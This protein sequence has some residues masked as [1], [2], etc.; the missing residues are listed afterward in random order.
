MARLKLELPEFTL[1]LT[2]VEVR[3]TDLNYGNHLANQALL[4]LLHE[5]RL[6]WLRQL[7]FRDELNV[8]DC[9]LVMSDAA[10]VFLRE[11]FLGEVLTIEL[12]RGECTRTGFDLYYL[13]TTGQDRQSVAQ[14]KTFMTCFDYSTRRVKAIPPELHLALQNKTVSAA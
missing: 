5:A 10:V 4:G 11:A 7:G 3:V 8:G 13:V 14:A 6:R 1:F 9:G 12:R 2:C